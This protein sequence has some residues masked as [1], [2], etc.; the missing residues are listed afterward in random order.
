MK[1]TTIYSGNLIKHYK[2]NN[3][4]HLTLSQLDNLISKIV[5]QTISQS[6]IV[7]DLYKIKKGIENNL[8]N[9]E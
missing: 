8:I 1:M 9:K 2:L 5:N 6:T 7:F 4:K 3:M